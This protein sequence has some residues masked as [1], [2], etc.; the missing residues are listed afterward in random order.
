MANDDEIILVKDEDIEVAV[1]RQGIVHAKYT[2]L[3]AAIF[4]AIWGLIAM[5]VLISYAL[6]G[7]DPP[8]WAVALESSIVTGSLAVIFRD[9]LPS[10]SDRERG[11]GR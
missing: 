5:V 4:L 10:A 2:F 8:N 7:L 11:R 6:R 9:H 3:I 1:A